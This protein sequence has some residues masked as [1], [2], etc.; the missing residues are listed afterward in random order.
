[1]DI[2]FYL[3]LSK[4]EKNSIALPLPEKILEMGKKKD[5]IFK[6]L[7]FCYIFFYFLKLGGSSSDLT[8]LE[9]DKPFDTHIVIIF[10]NKFFC[11]QVSLL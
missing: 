6:K 9:P 2:K 7:H 1:M 10:D 8:N 4:E 3:V 11:H 5:Y